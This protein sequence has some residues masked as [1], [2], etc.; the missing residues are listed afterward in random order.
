PFSGFVG[1]S[2]EGETSHYDLCVALLFHPLLLLT[3]WSSSC[4]LCTPQA[5][6]RINLELEKYVLSMQK[7][8]GPQAH[9]AF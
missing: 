9:C 7:A 3:R 1:L 2:P 4:S 6:G 5:G 8:Q